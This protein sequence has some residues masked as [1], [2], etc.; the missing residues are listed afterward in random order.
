MSARALQPRFEP[1]KEVADTMPLMDAYMPSTQKRRRSVPR[2]G[3][4]SNSQTEPRGGV[5]QITVPQAARDLATLSDIGYQDAFV[6]DV[7]RPRERTA[8]QWARAI[9][10][11]ASQTLR[12]RLWS[13]WM[14]LGLRLAPPFS[15][16]HVLG[17]EIRRQTPDFVLLGA[18]SR[19]GMPA[20]LLVM[21]RED[22]LLFDTFVQKSNPLARAVWAGIEPTHE[23]VLPALLSQF[24]RR[25]RQTRIGGVAGRR[26]R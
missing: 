5:R 9:L 25:I 23:R 6:I 3:Y 18:R 1:P 24:R 17:W 7:D 19:I 20:E 12:L 22:G 10:D 26:G 21:R 8:E 14:M 16:R 2:G 13:A 11:G 4:V 15:K